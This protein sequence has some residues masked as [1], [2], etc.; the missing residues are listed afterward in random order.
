VEDVLPLLETDV[1]PELDGHA[2][3]RLRNMCE[4]YSSVIEHERR[5]LRSLAAAAEHD[6][7]AADG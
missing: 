2:A 7:E 5:R 3:E 4:R 6:D 1:V